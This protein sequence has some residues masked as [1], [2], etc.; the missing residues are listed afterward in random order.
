M[1][2]NE[3][4]MVDHLLLVIARWGELLRDGKLGDDEAIGRSLGRLVLDIVQ[5]VRA[6]D[7]ANR[8]RSNREHDGQRIEKN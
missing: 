5:T 4:V 3:R 6:C 1:N 8:P 7:I 2:D